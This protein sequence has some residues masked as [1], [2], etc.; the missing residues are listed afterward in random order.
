MGLGWVGLTDPN[1]SRAAKPSPSGLVGLDG[2][3]GRKGFCQLGLNQISNL[4]LNANS[5]LSSNQIQ[6]FK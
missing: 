4:N 6:K 1:P 5:F 3:M 2:Q